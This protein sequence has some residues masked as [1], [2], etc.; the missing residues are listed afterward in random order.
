MLTII[1]NK[2]TITNRNIVTE[3]TYHCRP[4]KRH[5]LHFVLC[6]NNGDVLQPRLEFPKEQE[7]KNEEFQQF[8]S[9]TAL[10]L[11]CV[12]TVTM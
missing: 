1:N 12:R 4:L 5:N 2:Q 9:S 3:T 7:I 8:N 11:S 10:S 6:I